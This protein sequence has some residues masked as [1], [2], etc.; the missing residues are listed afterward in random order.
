MSIEIPII[1]A[2]IP[3]VINIIPRPLAKSG[4]TEDTLRQCGHRANALLRV[5]NCKNKKFI[6]YILFTKYRCWKIKF[7]QCF[8]SFIRRL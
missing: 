8:S 1:R 4:P 2:I 7:I 6:N 3:I 5:L